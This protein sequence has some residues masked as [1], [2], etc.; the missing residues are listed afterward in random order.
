EAKLTQEDTR[1]RVQIYLLTLRRI[2]G[3][4]LNVCF[5]LASWAAIAYATVYKSDISTYLQ[6]STEFKFL[7]SLAATVGN[8]VPNLVVAAC[9]MMLPQATK[10]LTLLEGWSTATRARHLIYRLYLGK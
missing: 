9:G 10:T 8:L 2:C 4:F 5:I 7:G 3:G 1:T 6:E